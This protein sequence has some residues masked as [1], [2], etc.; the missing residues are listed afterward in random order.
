MIAQSSSIRFSDNVP[1]RIIMSVEL[2]VCGSR[3]Q[4]RGISQNRRIEKCR[5]IEFSPFTLCYYDFERCENKLNQYGTV[6]AR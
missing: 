3:V 1:N 4:Y 5:N 6:V 2:K